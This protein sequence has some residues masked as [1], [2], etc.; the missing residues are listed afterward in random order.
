M[1]IS[2]RVLL[3][4]IGCFV[5]A[6]FSAAGSSDELVE[7]ENGEIA[8]AEDINNNFE[9]L[10]ERLDALDQTLQNL[11]DTV[12]ELA[13]RIAAL[14]STSSFDTVFDGAVNGDAQLSEDRL[15]VTTTTY[16]GT[17][18]AL[19]SEAIST[20]KHYWEWTAACGPDQYGFLLGVVG[21]DN[22]NIVDWA[23]VRSSLNSFGLITDGARKYSG[24]DDDPVPFSTGRSETE[25]GDVFMVAVDLDANEL[26]LGKNGVWLGNASPEDNEEPAYPLPQDDYY[27]VVGTAAYECVPHTFTVNFGASNFSYTPPSG[28][29]MGYCPSGDC[30]TSH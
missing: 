20:G 14:E 22:S 2:K 25:E 3:A 10:N 26:Y 23:S 17:G 30:E 19:V 18:A 15:T 13:D 6:V 5:L 27:A 11:I 4:L 1:P 8:D 24:A 9:H 16:L 12:A 7:F 21:S 28:Y 29:F